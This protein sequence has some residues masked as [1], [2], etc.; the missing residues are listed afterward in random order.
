MGCDIH[1]FIEY[2]TEGFDRW[3]PFGGKINPGRYYG[4][5]AKFA[6]VRNYYGIKAISEPRGLPED[7]GWRAKSE[8]QLYISNTESEGHATPEQ[9]KKWVDAGYSEIHDTHWVTNPDWHSHSWLTPNEF[10]QALNEIKPEKAFEYFVVL[11]ALRS[12]EKQGCQAR[13]VFWFDN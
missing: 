5:F 9:A 7:A 6:G 1:L 2:K 4:L 8:N 3:S 10:E 11:D 12:F 13:L